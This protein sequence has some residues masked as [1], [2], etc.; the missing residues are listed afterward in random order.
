MTAAPVARR[1]GG[2]RWASPI[3]VLAAA[4]GVRLWYAAI[5]LLPVVIAVV[6]AGIAIEV[7]VAAQ[8]AWLILDWPSWIVPW[9][10]AAIV[11]DGIYLAVVA[12]RKLWR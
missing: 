1:F 12:A 7:T 2:E 6:V 4:L 9:L 3:T 10:F 8:I 11:G 5:W